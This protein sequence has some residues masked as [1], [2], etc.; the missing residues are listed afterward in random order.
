MPEDRA[1][2][3]A[4]ERL[5]RLQA[6]RDKCIDGEDYD[7]SKDGDSRPGQGYGPDAEGE[8]APQDQGSAE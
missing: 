3:A 1:G 5:Q 7:E 6:S 8:Q 4:A 2:R